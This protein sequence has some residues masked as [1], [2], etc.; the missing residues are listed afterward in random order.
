MGIIVLFFIFITIQNEPIRPQE[1]QGSESN[2]CIYSSSMWIDNK[3]RNYDA[4]PIIHEV[5]RPV[6]FNGVRF[7]YVGSSNPNIDNMNCDNLFPREINATFG[8]HLPTIV[9]YGGYFKVNE[10]RHFI[11]MFTNGQ[12]KS[13][14]LCWNDTVKPRVIQMSDSGFG[15]PM[16]CPSQISWFDENKTAGIIQNEYCSPDSPYYDRYIAE[17]R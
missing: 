3:S 2:N 13:L 14:T 12:T 17:I 5:N 15:G 6:E 1:C 16:F 4:F 9:N 11:A 7:A 8:H 10:T